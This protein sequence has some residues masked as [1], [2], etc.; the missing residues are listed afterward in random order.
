MIA[1]AV[2]AVVP[3]PWGM[4]GGGGAEPGGDGVA[5]GGWR[6]DRAED[7]AQSLA[8]ALWFDERDRPRRTGSD[9]LAPLAAA[10]LVRHVAMAE[11]AVFRRVPD[12]VNPVGGA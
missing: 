5:A 1:E 12:A 8:F 2:A 6:Q 11:F 7:V 3:H 4:G 9:H 10:Q